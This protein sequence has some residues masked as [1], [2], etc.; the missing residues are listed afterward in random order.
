MAYAHARKAWRWGD[1][2]ALTQAIRR[3]LRRA[4]AGSLLALCMWLLPIP[5]ALA[6]ALLS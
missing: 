1:G 2:V 6:G 3:S 5:L 4:Q